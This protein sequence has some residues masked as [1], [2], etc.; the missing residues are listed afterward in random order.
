VSDNASSWTPE[1]ITWQL[2]QLWD[3]YLF[4]EDARELRA[5]TYPLM[6]GATDFW[7]DYLVT[8]PADGSL[9]VSPSFSPEHGPY[10][11]GA[12]YSQT[13]VWE[14]FRNTIEASELLHEDRE[15]RARLERTFNRL[16]PGLRIGSWGQLQEWKQDWDEHG[17]G[18]RH[19][20]HLYPL[21]PSDQITETGTPRFFEAAR[22]SVEDRTA[23][24]PQNDIGWNRA[25]KINFYAR[26]LDGDMALRQENHLLWRNTF[27]NFLNDWPFQI[28]GN[29]GVTSGFV[30]MLV[31]S[32]QGFVDILPA[33]PSSWPTGEVHGLRARGAFTVDIAWSD[34]RART[35]TVSS[36][37]GGTLKVRTTL[38]DGPV[39][40]RDDHGRVTPAAVRDGLLVLETDRGA[41]YTVTGLG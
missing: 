9:V 24:T 5:T 8:D 39:E 7:M 23:N 34:G 14:L 26:L 12:T 37:N 31:Q 29:F 30:E 27:R 36:D 21:Y 28:D 15:Y 16:D 17:D 4:G 18:H 32:H 1:S 13:I 20:S 40:V 22:V 6:K 25:Q 33:L 35:V 3:H 41:T 10:S 19:S 11:A 38:T 2:R